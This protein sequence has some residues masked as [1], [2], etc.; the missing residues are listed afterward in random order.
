MCGESIQACH[1]RCA[2]W[3]L[4]IPVVCLIASQK[5][6]SKESGIV[7]LPV[8]FEFDSSS[9]EAVPEVSFCTRVLSLARLIS[10]SC[11][12]GRDISEFPLFRKFLGWFRTDV[13]VDEFV[14]RVA[15][16]A[17]CT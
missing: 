9:A 7:D 6:C 16:A 12:H 15:C 11:M 17:T 10:G 8:D 4:Q 1:L 14:V 2:R 13:V 3:D 5:I